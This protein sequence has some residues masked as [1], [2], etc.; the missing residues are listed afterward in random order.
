MS[1]YWIL[2]THK[3]HTC[4]IHPE[5]NQTFTALVNSEILYNLSCLSITHL[6]GLIVL[7]VRN[8]VMVVVAQ[9]IVV[10][11][12]VVVVVFV[13]LIHAVVPT[14]AGQKMASLMT[15]HLSGCLAL[16]LLLVLEMMVLRLLVEE[17]LCRYCCVLAA[18]STGYGRQL[19]GVIVHSH[20]H[21]R[22][23]N[24]LISR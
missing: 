11:H 14:A 6:G 10:S 20:R 18:R 4:M 1:K 24:P 21:G 17:M 13:L 22:Q 15:L 23:W 19:T 5:Y 7:V 2:F 3:M 12:I 8:V 9:S 16:L